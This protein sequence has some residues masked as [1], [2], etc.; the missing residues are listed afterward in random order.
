LFFRAKLGLG[1]LT[2]KYVS[3]LKPEEFEGIKPL[4]FKTLIGKGHPD[5]S[6]KRQQD[7]QEYFLHIINMLEVS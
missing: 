4:M 5:F 7:A 6:T 1:L 2:D 3:P